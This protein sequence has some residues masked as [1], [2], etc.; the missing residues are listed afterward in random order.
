MANDKKIITKQREE[1][2]IAM[3]FDRFEIYNDGAIYDAIDKGRDIPQY[4]FE[5]RE[6]LEKNNN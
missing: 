6:I 1:L 5:I 2:P 3:I 4:V